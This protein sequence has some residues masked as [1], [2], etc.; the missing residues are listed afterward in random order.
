MKPALRDEK[1]CGA[2]ISPNGPFRFRF[3]KHLKMD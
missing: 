3:L 2:P 1:L